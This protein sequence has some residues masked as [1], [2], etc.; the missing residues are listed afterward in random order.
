MHFPLFLYPKRNLYISL[1][2]GLPSFT[3][4]Y[5]VSLGFTGFNQVLLG[6]NG[7]YKVLPNFTGFCRVLLCFTESYWV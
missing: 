3:G 5:W 1:S 4:F 6:L 7:F 2:S